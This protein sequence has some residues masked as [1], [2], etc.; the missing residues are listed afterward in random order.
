MTKEAA[1][2]STKRSCKEEDGHMETACISSP[3]GDVEDDTRENTTFGKT[4]NGAEDEE[5]TKGFHGAHQS[6][7]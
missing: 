1:K 7:T 5:A 6:H 3:K 2:R 4:K